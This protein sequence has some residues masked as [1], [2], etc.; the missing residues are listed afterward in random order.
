[1][2]QAFVSSNENGS[3]PSRYARIVDYVVSDANEVFANVTRQAW[4]R[5]NDTTNHLDAASKPLGGNIGFADGHVAWRPFS[6][7]QKQ[8]CL[9]TTNDPNGGPFANHDSPVYLWW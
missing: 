4:V 6:Q 1:V 7:M 9:S 8:W 2:G 5:V 3:A